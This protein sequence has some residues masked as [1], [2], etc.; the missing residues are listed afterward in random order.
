MIIFVMQ[1]S[2]SVIFILSN[3]ISYDAQTSVNKHEHSASKSFQFNYIVNTSLQ[4]CLLSKHFL[5]L[6]CVFFSSFVS[7]TLSLEQQSAVEE[8]RGV[9]SGLR[10]S[11]LFA[12][13]AP[14]IPSSV[15]R[16]AGRTRGCRVK[17]AISS[18]EIFSMYRM[19]QQ[20]FGMSQ[21]SC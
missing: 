11:W 15:H 10:P 17:V 16:L 19:R 9:V 5:E 7:L 6:F 2:W 4:L 8:D 14:S 13:P 12:H 1:Q 20:I 21:T 3:K 18:R